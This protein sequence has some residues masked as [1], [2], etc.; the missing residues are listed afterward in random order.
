MFGE[1][2][3]FYVMIGNHPIETTIKN[4]VSNTRRTRNHRRNCFSDLYLCLPNAMRIVEH[5]GKSGLAMCQV[6]TEAIHAEHLE[7]E[8]YHRFGHVSSMYRSNPL[9]STWNTRAKT[10]KHCCGFGSAGK[11]IIQSNI[12]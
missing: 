5:I 4:W 10:Q 3:I 12:E 7:H 8:R 11:Y 2:T 1:T 6:C 9:R